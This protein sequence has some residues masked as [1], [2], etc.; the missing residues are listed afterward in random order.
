MRADLDPEPLLPQRVLQRVR[1]SVA[2]LADAEN[3][4]QEEV[5]ELVGDVAIG[6]HVPAKAVIAE[7]MGRD[8]PP[9]RSRPILAHRM[10]I[11]IDRMMI[12][13]RA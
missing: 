1:A 6:A 4:R 12:A 7:G 3:A 8:P 2:H 9:Y 10:I 13:H 11:N 5:L